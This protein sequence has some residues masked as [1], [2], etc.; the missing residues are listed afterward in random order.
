VTEIILLSILLFLAALLAAALLR[1]FLLRRDL[2]H[3]YRSLSEIVSAETNKLLTTQTFDREIVTLSNQINAVLTRSRRDFFEKNHAEAALK[4]AVTNISHD[5][6]TPLTSAL[7]YL[8]LMESPDTDE[9]KKARYRE[10]VRGRLETL[11]ALMNG[12]FEFAQIIEGNI[13]YDIRPV[14]VANVLRDTLSAAYGELERRNFSVKTDIPE[15]PVIC[16]CDADALRRVLQNLIKNVCVHGKDELRVCL[17]NNAAVDVPA[18]NGHTEFTATRNKTKK[19]TGLEQTVEKTAVIYIENK[20]HDPDKIDTERIFERFFTADASR[21][22]KNT[23]LGLA[24]AKEL[25]E[26][27]GGEISARLDGDVLV[28]RVGVNDAII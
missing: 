5:L 2:R 28:M 24:I 10:T 20:V 8:Q 14:N 4:R 23:G 1:T 21:T 7:G 25:T 26:R 16:R 18:A 27:M 6:R 3:L 11:S 19:G 9:N 22:S 17:E 13:V 15:T 12:L